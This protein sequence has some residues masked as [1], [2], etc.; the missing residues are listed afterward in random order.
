[1]VEGRFLNPQP[2]FTASDVRKSEPK[3]FFFQNPLVLFDFCFVGF[4]YIFLR[5]R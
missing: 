2:H 3:L 4:F 5:H 1:M